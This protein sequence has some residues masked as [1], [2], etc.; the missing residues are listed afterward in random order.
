MYRLMARRSWPGEANP[1]F[2]RALRLSRLNYTLIWF[3]QVCVCQRV[4]EVSQRQ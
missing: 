2:L 3:S 4:V 1:A